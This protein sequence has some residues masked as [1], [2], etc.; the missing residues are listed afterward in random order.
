MNDWYE[1][2]WSGTAGLASDAAR[3]LGFK[4]DLLPQAASLPSLPNVPGL[5]SSATPSALSSVAQAVSQAAANVAKSAP[6]DAASATQEGG[7][8]GS[9]FS[10][11]RDFFSSAATSPAASP[12]TSPVSP[13]ASASALTEPAPEKPAPAKPEPKP[14]APSAAATPA[15]AVPSPAVNAGF[16]ARLYSQDAGTYAKIAA[17]AVGAGALAYAAV[18]GKPVRKGR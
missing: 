3:N 15:A 1:Q 5:P 6:K 12:A 18:G 11:A 10:K 4:D 17:V 9:L 8:L 16:L 13:F 7:G 14:S 2:D